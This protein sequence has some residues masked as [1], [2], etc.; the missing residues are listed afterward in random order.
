[1]KVSSIIAF[2]SLALAGA[3][4]ASMIAPHG[5][6]TWVGTKHYIRI[7]PAIK[8][9]YVEWGNPKGEPV[10]LIHGYSDSSRAYS[11]IAPF[12][13]DS[14]KRYIAIDLRGHGNSSKPKCCYYVSDLAEDISD[15]IRTMGFEKVSVVGHSL[16]SI[17]AGVL[18]ST[19][20]EQIKKLVL[21]SSALKPGPGT[22]FLYDTLHA[23]SFPLDV[24]GD[25]MSMW[26]PN[27]SGSDQE[28]L[29][30]LRQE[31]AAMPKRAWL[32]IVKGLEIVDWSK[33]SRH[34]TAPTLILW[35]DQDELMIESDQIALRNA[36]PNARFIRYEGLGHSMYWEQ[37]ERVAR[38]LN[39][40][41]K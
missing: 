22:D 24:N 15:F 3:A 14:S 28:M 13:N 40:F 39:D 37:P 36:L 16:G 33:A 38:D 4:H 11:T 2:A 30:Y 27:S 8:M 18:A 35:G 32:G 9:A 26:A 21:I 34:I 17:T 29:R 5:Q 1:M 19:H 6:A 7:N 31:E 20:P 41:L 25:F 23:Q 10:I 12:L